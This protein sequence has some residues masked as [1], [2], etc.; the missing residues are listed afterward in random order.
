MQGC[1]SRPDL[2]GEI[3]MLE[4]QL[5]NGRMEVQLRGELL[6]MRDEELISPSAGLT[7]GSQVKVCGISSKPELNNQTGTL[8]KMEWP[9]GRWAV[10]MN[11]SGVVVSLKPCCLITA[12]RDPRM[13]IH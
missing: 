9:S 6:Q 10:R 7:V 13:L 3:V 8:R 5:A 11:A 4:K 12:M 2:N 1:V